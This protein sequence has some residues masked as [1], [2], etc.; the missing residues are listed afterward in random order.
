MHRYLRPP[1]VVVVPALIAGCSYIG[2]RERRVRDGKEG[3][4]VNHGFNPPAWREVSCSAPIRP[5]Q[6]GAEHCTV[7]NLEGLPIEVDCDSD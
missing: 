4:Y 7:A 1:F 5:P 6:E 2:P 3:C